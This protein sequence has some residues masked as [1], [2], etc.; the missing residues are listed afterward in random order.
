MP[1][2]REVE[3]VDDFFHFGVGRLF[4]SGQ[5]WCAQ[6]L[7]PP[8][9]LKETVASEQQVVQHRGCFKQLNVLEGACN[10]QGGDLVALH[11][12]QVLAL[13]VDLSSTGVEH[14]GDRIEQRGF[15]R[16]VGPDHGQHFAGPD[17]QAQIGNGLHAA[18]SERQFVHGQQRG[19]GVGCFQR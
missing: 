13:E 1:P 7:L 10:A 3:K 15:A 6:N 4:E 17:F 9:T 5:G 8:M 11:L 16:T 14:A 18:K 12:G 19:G 2:G